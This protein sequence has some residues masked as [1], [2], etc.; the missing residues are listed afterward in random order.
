MVRVP[1]NNL[2]AM[3][4]KPLCKVLD[5]NPYAGFS[6]QLWS[7]AVYVRRFTD[8]GR[9]DENSLLKIAALLND[10]YGSID[11]SALALNQADRLGNKERAKRYFQ[12]LAG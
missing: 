9:L 8:F 4:T 7:D 3:S 11:L 2:T 10:L 5:N 1:P 6:Q 12:A